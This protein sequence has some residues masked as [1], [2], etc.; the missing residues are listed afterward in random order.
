MT[1]V[2]DT[3]KKLIIIELALLFI[4]SIILFIVEVAKRDNS[5]KDG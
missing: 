2:S 1:K 3:K 5:K 4:T